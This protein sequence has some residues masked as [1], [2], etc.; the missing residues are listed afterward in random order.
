MKVTHG[1]SR[2]RIA[3][4]VVLGLAVGCGG[5]GD[6]GSGGGNTTQHSDAEINALVQGL[7]YDSAALLQVRD[8]PGGLDQARTQKGDP[9]DTP[10]VWQGADLI[11]CR[12]VDYNLQSN[13]V[14]VAILRPTNGIIWPGA[15]VKANLALL[16]G[17]P[18]PI[19]AAPGPVTLRVDLPGIGTHGTFVV[20]K[21]SNSSV[22]AALDGVLAWWN[23]NAAPDAYTN[24]MNSSSWRSTSYS[25][26]QL[27][28]D[29]GLNVRWASTDIASK[30]GYTSSTTKTVAMMVYKQVFYTVTLDTPSSPAVMFAD[31]VGASEL[32]ALMSNDSPPAYVHSVNFGRIVMFSMETS[33]AVKSID[34]EATMKYAAGVQVDLSMESKYKSILQKS[35]ISVVTIGGGALEGSYTPLA[36]SFGDLKRWI[37]GSNAVYSK[38]NPGVPIA[39]TVKF[40]K[41]NSIAKMGY[42]TDYTATE[43]SLWKP[44]VL[45]VRNDGAYIAR[46][47]VSYY[48]RGDTALK[49]VGSGNFTAGV[50]RSFTVPAGST[51][52]TLWA[53]AMIWPWP[54]VWGQ[55]SRQAWDIGPEYEKHCL[56]G[57]TT[58][59]S[60][61]HNCP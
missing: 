53:D 43:C 24:A 25:S 32:K 56:K 60:W 4:A 18:Q 33:E 50:T 19:T 22:Q 5:G 7:T 28:L 38:S 20:E 29:V 34:M 10:D 45:D 31:T 13:A 27:A 47:A 48:P 26:E 30:F 61:Q 15:L 40:L 36:Q 35:S 55:I 54:E 14:D 41:D 51:Q 11:A 6:G 17:T 3:L 9:K 59:N 58:I 23:D 52:V 57:T 37:E 39:Y 16:D 1:A 2:R 44:S 49:T 12:A 21:P 42:T 8:I 46:A